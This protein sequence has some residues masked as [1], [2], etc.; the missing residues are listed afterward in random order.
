L[1]YD[2]VMNQQREVAY[3]LRLFALEGG[4]ELK[5]EAVRMIQ[6]AM[7]RFA[8]QQGS[9]DVEH[10]DRKL[11]GADLLMRFLVSAPEVEDAAKVRDAEALA[12]LLKEKGEAAFKA[13]IEMWLD[14]EQ[15]YGIENLAEKLL[16]QVMLQV[17]DEKWKDHLYDLDQLRTA[18]QYRAWGQKDPLIEY[19]S[20]AFDLFADLMNDIRQSF[21]ERFLKLQVQLPG[22]ERRPLAGR[23]TQPMRPAA[24]PK[25]DTDFLVPGAARQAR[26]LAQ[27][28]TS[29]PGEP[30]SGPVARGPAQ[31]TVPK[32]GR[33]DPCPCGSGKKYKKCHGAGA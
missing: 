6:A 18:I 29:G 8:E 16:S 14:L 12:G 33:N 32:V 27:A 13:K 19:K 3:S 10:W 2:D 21:A 4:E 7:E 26:A 20:D 17:L 11:I 9:E 31:R 5:A 1:D 28:T 24:E 25:G 23:V 30:G 15:R 22:E